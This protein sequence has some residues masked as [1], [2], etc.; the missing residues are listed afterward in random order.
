MRHRWRTCVKRRMEHSRRRDPD[1]H[2]RNGSTVQWICRFTVRW[3]Y[4]SVYAPTLT[5]SHEL[6]VVTERRLWTRAAE[7][8]VL[9][10]VAGDGARK[11]QPLL[12]EESA[13]VAVRVRMPPGPLPRKVFQT[14]STGRRPRG[15]H[16]GEAVSLGWPWNR[17]LRILQQEMEKV[18]RAREVLAS[19]LGLLPL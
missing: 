9:R 14:C 7:M 8:N 19:L 17:H 12:C 2:L 1:T 18:S 6:C 16:T 11:K 4:P 5:Y 3:I 15:R 10:R 13:V